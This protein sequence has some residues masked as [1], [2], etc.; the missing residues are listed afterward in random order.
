MSN[1]TRDVLFV[2]VWFAAICDAAVCMG[3][4]VVIIAYKDTK[5]C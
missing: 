2:I 3:P 5:I 4:I 1:I